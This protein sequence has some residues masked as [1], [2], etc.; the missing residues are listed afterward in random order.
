MGKA[1]WFSVRARSHGSR[2][3]QQNKGGRGR[4]PAGASGGRVRERVRHRWGRAP[5]TRRAARGARRAVLCVYAS[6]P[7][8]PAAL[9]P[10][11]PSS[12]SSRAAP[13]KCLGEGAAS[14]RARRAVVAA[15][16]TK[17]LVSRTPR[18]PPPRPCRAAL[19]CSG[20]ACLRAAGGRARGDGS[21][22]QAIC[23]R[24]GGAG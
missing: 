15:Q 3:T 24:A 16:R 14:P 4:V 5:P 13:A 10:A 18:P 21:R 22:A 6:R 8:C 7:R 9:P 19:R 1:S 11:P 20:C 23:L 2:D 17:R 12:C